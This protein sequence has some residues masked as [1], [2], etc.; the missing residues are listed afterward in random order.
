MHN[1][2]EQHCLRWGAWG[3]KYLTY[4]FFEN[5]IDN[6][7]NLLIFSASKECSN[8]TIAMSMCIKNKRNLWGRYWGSKVEI[9]NLHFELCYYLPIEWAIKNNIKSFDPGAGGKHKRRRGFLAIN[10]KSYHKWFNKNME[11]IIV[12]WLTQVNLETI[13]EIEIENKSIPFN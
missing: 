13:K 6:K 2:Y 9:N 7:E 11:N 1:F 3:S 4:N 10:S 5:I 8:N 12:P